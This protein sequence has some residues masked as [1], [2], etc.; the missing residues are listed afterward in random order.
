MVLTDDNLAT[1]VTAVREGRRIYDNVRTFIVYIFAH[2]IPEVVPFLVFALSGGRVPLPLTVL[3]ILAIDLGTET[4]PAVGLGREPAEPGNMQQPPRSPHQHLVTGRLLAAR[5]D[6]VS[7]FR[8]GVGTNRLLLAGVAFE[9]LFTAA[10]V[11]LPTMNRLLGAAPLPWHIVA[12]IALLSL[13][14]WGVDELHR[15]RLR[16][17]PQAGT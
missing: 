3:Q 9:L 14:V 15:A 7:L 8:V 5:T 10:L 2:A 13:V 17:V 1:V 4:V 16:R 6:R 11:Y 12:F